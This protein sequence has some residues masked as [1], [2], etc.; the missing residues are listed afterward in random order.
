M[1]RSSTLLFSTALALLA[2]SA[3][4]A[5][6]TVASPVVFQ[7]SPVTSYQISCDAP[8]CQVIA[9]PA[10]DPTQIIAVIGTVN[11]E[12]LSALSWSATPS[13]GTSIVVYIT[14]NTGATGNNS[15]TTIAEGTGECSEGGSSSSSGDSSSS[16]PASSANSAASSISESSSS[17][18]SQSSS[19]AA[20]SSSSASSVVTTSAP[21]STKSQSQ[22]TTASGTTASASPSDVGSGASSIAV[23]GGTINL[24]PSID[25][26]EIS[27]TRD[28]AEHV[29]SNPALLT[30]AIKLRSG[31]SIPRIGFGVYQ[32]TQA[33][34]SSAHALAFGYRH[35][36][37]ARVYRNESEVCEAVKIFQKNAS[38]N[39]GTG[40]VFLTTKVTGK[41]HGTEKTDKAV[42]ESIARAKEYGLVW[43]L[44]LLHDATSGPERRKEAWEVL[45]KKRDEGK[46]KSIGVSNFNE[47][48]LQQ[49]VDAGLEIPAVNQIELHPFLQQKP[50]VE[51]CQKN[52]VVVEAYCPIMRG[53]NFADP[54]LRKLA[55]K[56][57]AT[58]AQIL[59][60]WSLQK[61]FVPLPKSDTPGR[62]QEN[63]D[64]FGLTLDEG[65]MKELDSL[66]Q[67]QGKS[68]SWNPVDV[69]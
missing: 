52:D 25:T 17:A 35:I 63:F 44:F 41:E 30:S 32:S 15:P 5:P 3:L 36:D 28:C 37:S 58:V 34:A 23:G 65:D 22:T 60:R 54:I 43:D 31:D 48:H 2:T 47:K 46:I 49:L 4:G 7:C 14:D 13:A 62:I 1:P 59:I 20:S 12:G 61:G 9:R 6:P 29:A 68:V 55:K 24:S 19:S 33:K 50:I 18:S 42:E 39:S 38:A 69:E 67:G 64:V 8:P 53:Q 51:W 26:S 56:H 21:S 11:Q 66:D 16:A 45:M 40:G 10:N 27:T 57:D